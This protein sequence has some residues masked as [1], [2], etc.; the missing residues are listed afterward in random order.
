MT[1]HFALA[2]VA[3]ATLC[4][5]SD[6][7][8]AYGEG[9]FW[10]RAGALRIDPTGSDNRLDVAGTR[11]DVSVDNKHTVKAFTLGYRFTDNVGVELLG[12]PESFKHS[13]ALGGVEK[14]ATVDLLPPTLTAQYYP[15]GGTPSQVQPYVGAGVNYT[16]FSSTH[17]TDAN[18][19]DKYRLDM[20]SSWGYALQAGVDFNVSE[21]WGANLGVWYM[22]VNSKTHLEDK[23]SGEAAGS[24]TTLHIDPIVTMAGIAYRF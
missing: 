18:I 23:A 14:S 11:V 2:L 1:K 19:D 16:R 3:T 17:I 12:A 22:D 15:L 24:N 4:S 21:H 6:A 7:A 8:H 10:V 5:L 9:D 20:K 13:I